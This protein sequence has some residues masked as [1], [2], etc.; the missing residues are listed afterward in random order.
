[1]KEC[2]LLLIPVD[3]RLCLFQVLEEF[4]VP[5]EL[6]VV[7]AH[8]TPEKMMEYAR[9]GHK[10]GLKAIIAGAGKVTV[11]LVNVTYLSLLGDT[12]LHYIFFVCLQ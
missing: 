6:T 5:F 9:T 1:M 3:C 8:R 2:G 10:R 12:C 11:H 7:S 4:G